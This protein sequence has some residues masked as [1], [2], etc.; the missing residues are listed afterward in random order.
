MVLLPPNAIMTLVAITAECLS[1]TD[2]PIV[3]LF[4]ADDILC[5]R[6]ARNGR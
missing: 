3:V 5:R 2:M 4:P 1:I 6:L